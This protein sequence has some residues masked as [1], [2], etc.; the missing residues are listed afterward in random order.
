MIKTLVTVSKYM[1]KVKNKDNGTTSIEVI[2]DFEQVFAHKD[3]WNFHG[4]LSS[5]FFTKF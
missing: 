4:I 3:P 5:L 1:F 2:F